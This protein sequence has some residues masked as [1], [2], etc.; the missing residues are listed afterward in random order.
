MQGS[1]DTFI[2]IHALWCTAGRQPL[3]S[4]IVRKVLFPS[5]KKNAE[6]NGIQVLAVNGSDEHIHCLFKLMPVQSVLKMVNQLKEESF[7]WLNNNKLSNGLF[8]WEND[9]SAWS[10]SPATLDK[11]IE[12]IHNQEEYHRHKSFEEELMAFQKMTI[13]KN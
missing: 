2:Y 4:P 8:E 5:L 9:Y 12:Y 7:T 1:T 6:E 13:L 11:A 10:V 3:L